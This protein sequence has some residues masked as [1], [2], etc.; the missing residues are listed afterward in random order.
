VFLRAPRL[1]PS[2]DL[3]A[4]YE[5]WPR[6]WS[7]PAPG[8]PSGMKTQHVIWLDVLLCL[9][10]VVTEAVRSHWGWCALWVVLATAFTALH[11]AVNWKRR[12]DACYVADA[13]GRL[14]P[15]RRIRAVYA[16]GRIIE[17]RRHLSTTVSI[18]FVLASPILFGVCVALIPWHPLGCY[19]A[20]SLAWFWVWLD[21]LNYGEKLVL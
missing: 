3:E 5:V 6:A 14:Y 20:Y 11:M 12:Q 8:Q 13:E 4:R 16:D 10:C 2:V 17:H 9:A 1:S 19:L 18:L 21:L 7:Y 15:V